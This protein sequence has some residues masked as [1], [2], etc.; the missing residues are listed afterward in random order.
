MFVRRMFLRHSNYTGRILGNAQNCTSS[1]YQYVRSKS[2][3]SVLF[4][5]WGATEAIGDIT[6]AADWE[7]LSCDP[8]SLAQD[9]RIV[10]KSADSASCDHLFATPSGVPSRRAV[11]SGTLSASAAN[12]SG[13]SLPSDGA[14][15]GAV[16]KIVRLPENVCSCLCFYV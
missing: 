10:C 1:S 7:I 3:I 12:A 5:Q 11:T 6:Q 9:I 14:E 4:I 8:Q 2:S 15:Q 13:T 16:G